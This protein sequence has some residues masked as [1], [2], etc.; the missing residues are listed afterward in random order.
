VRKNFEGVKM[1]DKNRQNDFEW[2]WALYY[3]TFSLLA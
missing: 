1:A 3:T 2:A